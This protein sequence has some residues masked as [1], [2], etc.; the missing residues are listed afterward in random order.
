ML[1]AFV[2]VYLLSRIFMAVLPRR[3]GFAGVA[4]VYGACGVAIVAIVI[5][6]RW[7]SGSLSLVKLAIY[8]P[9]LLIWPMIDW[10]RAPSSQSK[11]SPPAR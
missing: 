3:E 7:P 11:P 4:R 10:L 2:M 9:G 5:G 1:G 6:A 8:A